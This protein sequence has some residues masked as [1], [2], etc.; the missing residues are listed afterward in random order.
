MQNDEK[1]IEK[2]WAAFNAASQAW[3]NSPGA[4]SPLGLR[5]GIEQRYA[6]T[7]QKL[8]RL[9]VMPQIRAKYRKLR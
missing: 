2:A 6:F 8:V 7:Y 5:R 1:E 3:K 9:G 4:S